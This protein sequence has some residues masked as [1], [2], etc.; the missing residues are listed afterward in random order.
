MK[1]DSGKGL[2]GKR[3]HVYQTPTWYEGIAEILS[4]K[5]YYPDDWDDPYAFC[6][7]KFID[8]IDDVR[9]YRWISL[10]NII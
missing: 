1:K 7:V 4:V 6:L 2:I 5:Q 10:K 3:V 8:D 9:V